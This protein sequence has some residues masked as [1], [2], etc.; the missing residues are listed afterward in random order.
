MYTS[1]WGYVYVWVCVEFKCAYDIYTFI[2]EIKFLLHNWH[3][4]D[5]S[6]VYLLDRIYT[7]TYLRETNMNKLCVDRLLWYLRCWLPL[8]V[9]VQHQVYVNDVILYH[10]FWST[11]HALSNKP[12]L[13]KFNSSFAYEY[14]KFTVSFQN[15][16]YFFFFA[17]IPF[18]I[19]N[20]KHRYFWNAISVYANFILPPDPDQ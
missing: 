8:A 1:L 20:V 10:L 2:C 14:K 6:Y 16:Q 5:C 11:S 7:H 4:Y 3:I 18:V 19:L 15:Q 17:K 9:G 12:I 13:S